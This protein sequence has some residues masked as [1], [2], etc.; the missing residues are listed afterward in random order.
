[1]KTGT[2]P[3]VAVL[4]VIL[5]IVTSG[6]TSSRPPGASPVPASPPSA[7]TGAAVTGAPAG[8]AFTL[9]VDAVGDGDRLP[10]A[11]SCAAGA[12]ESPPVSWEN[13]PAGTK[14]LTLIME[15]RDAANGRFT[16]WI[17]YNIPPGR[18]SIPQGETAVKE[19]AGGG[20]EGTN[21]AGERVYYPA[22]PPIGPEHRYVFTLY[23]VD[24]TMDF[25]TADRD[26]IDAA[27]SLD[28][29]Q[30]ILGKSVVTT[31]FKR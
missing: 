22:C 23:A 26:G 31:T 11:Y 27:L 14:T 4:T 18:G 8:T 2:I 30:H 21:S 15:D 17:I 5:C 29:G 7:G 24:Y 10:P 12:P 19:L 6:C 25:P 28:G 1:M 13:V 16:H 3:L 9:H 20:Q